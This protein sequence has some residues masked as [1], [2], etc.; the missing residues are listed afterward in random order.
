MALLALQEIFR[1]HREKATGIMKLGL[2]HTRSIFFD[3]G[4]VVFAQSTHPLD[5]LTHLLVER[6]KLT[7]AQLDYAL[8]NL[9]SGISIGKNLIEMGFITQRDLLEVARAQVERVVC[10][11]LGNTEEPPSFEN[12]ADLDATVVRLP[13]H[14]PE[15][16]LN[17]LLGIKNREA[18]LELLGPLNQV[19]VLQGRHLMD[20]SLPP[21]LVALP[22]LLDGTHTLLELSR[23]SQAEPL[24]LGIFALFLREMGWARLHEMPPLDKGA[25]DLA[26]APDPDV[27]PLTESSLEAVSSLSEPIQATV[28][29]LF[30]SIQA[31]SQPTT[32]LDHLAQ[33]LDALPD[34]NALSALESRHTQELPSESFEQ[35]MQAGPDATAADSVSLPADREGGDFDVATGQAF[36]PTPATPIVFPME[37]DENLL[38]APV[39]TSEIKPEEEVVM[40]AAIASRGAGVRKGIF[41][42]PMLLG[43]IIAGLLGCVLYVAWRYKRHSLYSTKKTIEEV[44][45]PEPVLPAEPVESGEPGKGLEGPEAGDAQ[46]GLTEAPAAQVPAQTPTQAGEGVSGAGTVQPPKVEPAK[47]TAPKPEIKPE[48]KPSN[49]PKGRLDALRRGDMKLASE[50]GAKRLREIPGKRWTLRLVIACQVDTVKR[51]VDMFGSTEPDLWVRPLSL[52]GKGC[53]Q[54]FLGSYPSREAAEAQ[55][56]KLPSEFQSKGSRAYPFMVSEIPG[57]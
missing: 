20:L 29:S 41:S 45:K 16:L 21:D 35:M 8:S 31:A 13:F 48:T 23:E 3:S 38:K 49:L 42:N 5:R 22:P 7:Q 12:S 56:S 40:P 17:A 18:F 4:D 51:A 14:T 54:I 47:E 6:G 50:Q 33:A 53:Y 24:R 32:N 2:E 11:A 1:C 55:I 36:L 28:P 39:D 25:L 27:L 10:G 30:A 9:K 19:V 57:R 15:L 37:E 34:P 46:K 26:L 44:V 52:K 43:A